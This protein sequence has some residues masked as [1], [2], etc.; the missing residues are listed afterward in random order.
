MKFQM[1]R[2]SQPKVGDP[3]VVKVVRKSGKPLPTEA[4]L[5]E[6]AQRLLGKPI[7][8]VRYVKNCTY[9]MD[10]FQNDAALFRLTYAP[11]NGATYERCD[12]DGKSLDMAHMAHLV[13]CGSI[14]KDWNK[15]DAPTDQM[16]TVT[17]AMLS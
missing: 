3:K 13:A 16:L 10:G 1:W 14:D 4:Q 7:K 15:P 6:R 12:T 9:L 8:S 5:I 17:L 11:P 2:G